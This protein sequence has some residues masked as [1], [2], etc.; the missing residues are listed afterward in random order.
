M[1]VPICTPGLRDDLCDEREPF[2]LWAEYRHAGQCRCPVSAF[3]LPEQ[4]SLH[5]LLRRHVKQIH[6][7]FRDRAPANGG[8][9]ASVRR[10]TSVE[11]TVLLF[12]RE[13]SK[14]LSG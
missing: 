2:A 9:G 7:L 14:L 5:E 6:L 12:A 3:F 4:E 13:G 8:N 11:Q 10:E 1:R